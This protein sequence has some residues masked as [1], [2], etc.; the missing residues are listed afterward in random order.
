[1]TLPS[2][3][4]ISFSDV[5]T[6]LGRGSTDEMSLANAE[7]GVYA[8]INQ[9][10]PS[11]PNGSSPYSM[12][13]WYGYNHN[14]APAFTQGVL[15]DDPNYY[16]ATSGPEACNPTPNPPPDPPPMPMP[17]DIWYSGT[18]GVGDF[19]YFDDQGQNHLIGFFLWWKI[20]PAPN[21]DIA[22]QVNNS[23]EILDTF[24]C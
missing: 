2:S 9:N 17:I 12:S 3:G 23:G 15:Y 13:E 4:Q 8:P 11:R 20:S 5:N 18:A 6:E 19:I 7:T 10:S 1:M 16:P 21:P 14:A 22:V 24:M